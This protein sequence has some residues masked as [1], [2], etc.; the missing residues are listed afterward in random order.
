MPSCS[1]QATYLIKKNG[2]YWH[3][4]VLVTQKKSL[5]R[6]LSDWSQV[7]IFVQLAIAFKSFLS[8]S[9]E[10]AASVKISRD[11]ESSVKRKRSDVLDT[12][13][14]LI[15]NEQNWSK[16]ATETWVS[17]GFRLV[18][19]GEISRVWGP[20][21]KGRKGKIF[22]YSAYDVYINSINKSNQNSFKPP[23]LGSAVPLK[24]AI[25]TIH[26]LFIPFDDLNSTDMVKTRDNRNHFTNSPQS[27]SPRR[28]QVALIGNW[29]GQSE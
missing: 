27:H 20:K 13:R 29:R 12:I 9:L 28:P 11:V 14:S 24:N 17:K 23:N 7:T 5:I 10:V 25:F 8:I 22:Q 16:H 19:R 21:P 4:R 26:P 6:I 3:S 2:Y 1:W 18:R 15:H